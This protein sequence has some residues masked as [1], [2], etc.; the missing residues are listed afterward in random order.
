MG[1]TFPWVSSA[2]NDFNFDFR[3][4]LDPERENYEYNYA[5]AKGLIAAG[6]LNQQEDRWKQDFNTLMACLRPTPTW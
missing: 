2:G 3:V 4:T 1:W 6:K 5:S